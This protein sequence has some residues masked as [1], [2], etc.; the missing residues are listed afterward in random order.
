MYLCATLSDSRIDYTSAD[1]Q[2]SLLAHFLSFIRKIS[3][4]ASKE[5]MYTDF[6]D[7]IDAINES[8]C[9]SFS[10]DK[11]RLYSY[12]K[13][14]TV[15]KARMMAIFIAHNDFAVSCGKLSKEYGRTTRVIFGICQKMRFILDTYDDDFVVYNEI[16][17]NLGI[18]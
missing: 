5:I 3:I 10:V 14:L 6:R 15:N 9:K 7:I 16:K 2:V 18:F 12:D 4:F 8:V 11:E 1:R 13:H 17:K